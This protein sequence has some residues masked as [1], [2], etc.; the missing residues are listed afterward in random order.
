MSPRRPPRLWARLAVAFTAGTLSYL[1]FAVWLGLTLG[2]APGPGPQDR[3][4]ALAVGGLALCIV[5]GLVSLVALA[6]A[7]VLIW[8]RLIAR[9]P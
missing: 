6:G 7:L 8:K 5:A 4:D 2:Y 3:N 1:G 9:R